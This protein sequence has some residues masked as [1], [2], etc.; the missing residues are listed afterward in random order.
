[1]NKFDKDVADAF[2]AA[3]FQM[4]LVGGAVR[5][6]LLG[7]ES[8]D[9]DYATDASLEEA[10]SVTVPNAKCVA[11]G[12]DYE[13]VAFY[14]DGFPKVDV[15]RF[16]VEFGHTEDRKVFQSK[17][18]QT[19]EEDL[20]RRDFT[21]NA[22]AV[23][24]A[25]GRVVDPFRGAKDLEDRVLRFVDDADERVDEDPL[26]IMR[27]FRFLAR[28][29]MEPET[30]S[31]RAC[32]RKAERLRMVSGERV[33]E[34]MFKLLKVPNTHAVTRALRLMQLTGVMAVVLP[35]L[36]VLQMLPY[37]KGYHSVNGFEHTM[38]TLEAYEGTD[39]VV[40]LSLVLHD[41]GKATTVDA[42]GHS[43]GHPEAGVE[44]VN[45]IA[46]RLR[47][48]NQLRDEVSFL[49]ASHM[50]R[51]ENGPLARRLKRATKGSTLERSF[52]VKR[53]DIMGR[54]PMAKVAEDAELDVLY[55]ELKALLDS[56]PAL[57]VK[58][59]A[60][61]GADLMAK[62][63]K[64]GPDMGKMLNWML[65]AVLDGTVDNDRDTLLSMV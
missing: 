59:L 24:M 1:M 21:I 62:G 58:D 20:A 56:K 10:Q 4:Y 65:S 3:G 40:R 60:V 49:V 32:A 30:N 19:I 64:P 11:I 36:S 14:R 27:F 13:I 46:V 26:R 18:V 41:V 9:T 6:S 42:E 28:F 43:Y 2:V 31:L 16:R 25:T 55:R 22:M 12:A 57:T 48:T 7:M 8:N 52:A 54:G 61:S 39:F 23:C 63:V 37:H 17:P 53:A 38:L 29:D 51:L 5:D 33:R 47:F 45:Q 35:E 15:A 34:E 50:D 44:L